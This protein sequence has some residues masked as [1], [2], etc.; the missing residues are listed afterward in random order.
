MATS[1][2][3][4]QVVKLGQFQRRVNYFVVKAAVA[5]MNEDPL[6]AN[7]TERVAFANSVFVSDYNL[8]QYTNSILAN[9]TIMSGLTVSDAGNGVTDSDLEFVV[10][11]VY[12]AFA[13]VST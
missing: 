5:V 8:E 3:V 7:H 10:N 12:D 13:G 11:S 2:E 4:V 9:P 1:V 6:T